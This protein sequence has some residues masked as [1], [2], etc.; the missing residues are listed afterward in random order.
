MQGLSLATI[1]LR[2]IYNT[3]PTLPDAGVSPTHPFKDTLIA[4]AKRDHRFR[5]ALL[6]EC[7]SAFKEGDHELGEMLL[8]WIAST[9]PLRLDLGS[10]V[11]V[12]LLRSLQCE[13]VLIEAGRVIAAPPAFATQLIRC[14]WAECALHPTQIAL[15]SS[16][17]TD[18]SP[19]V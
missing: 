13:S 10:G 7:V 4:R 8:Q 1:K 16:D 14:G 17:T 19:R 15:M 12:R 11:C 3:L 6:Q 2:L 9:I 18:Q 5:E